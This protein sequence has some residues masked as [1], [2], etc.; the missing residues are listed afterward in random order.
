MACRRRARVGESAVRNSG[1]RVFQIAEFAVE[2]VVL[3]VGNGRGGVPG[4]SAGYGSAISER[5]ASMRCLA[6]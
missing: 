1:N 2:S 3:L 5:S 6:R 4:N